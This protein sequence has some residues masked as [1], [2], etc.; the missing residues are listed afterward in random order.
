MKKLFVLVSFIVA[1]SMLL[2]GCGAA[3][4]TATMPEP[5]TAAPAA[6]A[7]T[8]MPAPTTAP[9]AA[10][11]AGGEIA[12]IVKTGNSGY[13]QNVQAGAV[14]AQKELQATTPKL[15]VTFLGAQ[16]ESNIDEEINIVESAIDR[17][18]KA[19]V[20]APSDA[21]ALQ[22]AVADAK[23]AGIPVIIIDS[24]LAGDPSQYVSFLATDN[25]AAG[26]AIAKTLVDT[27]TAKGVT[28]GKLAIM[29]YVAG[30]GSEIG[31]VGGFTDYIKANSKFTIISPNQYSNSDVATALN[32]TT[33][34][35]KANPDLVGIF[36]S[37]EPTAT[38]MGQAIKAAGLSGKIV[39][40]GFDGNEAEQAFITDGTLQAIC[41]QSSYNLGYLGVK[42]AYDVAFNNKT[43]PATVDT[44]Y[45]I[46]TK[47]NLSS[48]A[49]KGVLY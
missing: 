10:A 7:A 49:A 18:V 37:N 40:V 5:A 15:S 30:A 35:L 16:S 33:N 47:D 46:V 9:A 1:A 45:L 27:L 31:R 28:T 23:K 24:A 42:D 43:I 13:W 8:A 6:P 19:I 17:N 22:P 38:G 11:P 44:G 32:Q 20:L 14:K 39:A 26:A 48:D 4:P 29:S 41:V 25:K 36:G 12:V 21:T 3:T 2:A 34:V